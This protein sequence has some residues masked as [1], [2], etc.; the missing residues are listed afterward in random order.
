MEKLSLKVQVISLLVA[1]LT[2]LTLITSYIAISKSK[3]ALLHDS[4]SSLTMVRD[5]KKNQ[6]EKFFHER[7][8][9]INVLTRSQDLKSLVKDLILTHEE[10]E[11]AATDPYPVQHE[12][13]LAQTKPYEEFFQAYMKDY[14]YYDVFVICAK[15]GHVMYTAAKESDLG[16]NLLSGPL[17]ESGLAKVYKEAL[18]NNRPSFV[19]M[20]PYVPS[21]NI[22]A[23][24]LATPVTI[25]G[26][27]KAILAFQ[28]SDSAIN[29]VMQYR[30]GYG[31]T[32]EDYLVGPDKLMRSDSYL[33]PQEHSLQASFANPEK[34]SVDTVASR[35]ALS[36]KTET[37]IVKDYNGNTVLSSY[38]NIKVGEDFEWAIL[39]EIDEAEVMIVPSA[40][41]N[42]MVVA[43]ILTLV[44]II[45]IALVM[46][47]VSLTQHIEKLKK[48]LMQISK[49]NDLTIHV[50][51]KAPLEL[52]LIA[53]SFNSLRNNLQELIRTSKESSSENA[54]ISHELSTTALNVG[55][56][57][58][59][60][61]SVIDTASKK[62]N[63]TKDEI[64]I[65]IEDAQKSKKDIIAANDKLAVASS[66]LVALTSRVQQSAQLEVELAHKMDMLST[67]ANAVKSVLE[68]IS[69]IA[70]QT[71][72]LALNAA[73]EAA[74]AGEH[75][76]GFAVVADEVRKLAERTQKSLT[77]I[78]ATI[79]V[80]VQSIMD[81]SGQMNSNSK[82]VQELTNVSTNV[83]HKINESVMLVETALR[84]SD[85][86]VA[87]FEKTGKSIESI[88]TQVTEINALSAQN[89]R[90][91]EE[92]AA[93]AEHLNSM[94]DHLHTK[95]ETFRT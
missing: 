6:I 36:G 9:D 75:G 93:A 64:I 94:T 76:R 32:Q 22:P 67:E 52:S 88:V 5:M 80:I 25:D 62:A 74:R 46:I 39:S 58:E 11:V 2:I 68:I 78:N 34:G 4:Y 54:S 42:T 10:L 71:N 53:Q 66:D 59:K 77:E 45:A 43:S 85:K 15:H 60:S 35:E 27:V 37:K 3:S 73:I 87:D 82:E 24:F 21:N 48:S 69:D 33:N 86:T 57:V 1:S 56:N 18:Q 13:V 47:K 29:K 89:A 81:V 50:D 17:K 44:I 12:S 28:I 84:A 16:T 23:M 92:I 14:G 61:V 90:N 70:D 83:E 40:I 65:A 79:N 7:V 51:E 49:D 41:G 19:D 91:V 20:E 72:L 55:N 95:L 8:G 38:S 31:D 63:S 30:S 26:E